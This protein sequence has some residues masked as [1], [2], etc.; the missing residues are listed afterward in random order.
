MTRDRLIRYPVARLVPGLRYTAAR[1]VIGHAHLMHKWRLSGED[2][3]N[4]NV[5]RARNEPSA[6]FLQ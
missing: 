2:S 4:V 6:K 3:W 1:L 5:T